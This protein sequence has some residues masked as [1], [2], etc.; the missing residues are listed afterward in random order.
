[1]TT[2]SYLYQLATETPTRWW[3]DSGDPDEIAAALKNRAAGITTNPV[4]AAATLQCS[5]GKW[6]AGLRESSAEQCL[7]AVVENAAAMLLPEYQQSKGRNGYV[8]AQVDPSLAGDREA[9]H[10]MAK[11]FAAWAPNVAVKLPATAAGLDILEEC[12]STG[13]TVCSTVSF[14]LPQVLAAAERHRRGTRRAS[15]AG[16]VPG[17]GFAVIMI[18]RLD[19]YLRDIALDGNYQ[20]RETDIKQ[21]GIAVSKRTYA[22]LKEHGY[23]TVLMIAALRG[24]YHAHAF[25]GDDLILSIHPKYQA[26]LLNSAIPS[27]AGAEP[28]SSAVIDRL[29]SIP[30]FVRSYEPDGMKPAEFLA[31]GLTQRT[32]AQFSTQGWMQLQSMKGGG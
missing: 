25:V 30:E 21:A 8:C 32:L 14:T 9:M 4:L 19:D 16:I 31:F 13:I 20:G 22:L 12:V 29:K 28:V 26:E 5:P 27:A 15:N 10:A 23:E 1:M 6:P 17:R 11:R 18:G 24:V 7:R 3:H 2:G